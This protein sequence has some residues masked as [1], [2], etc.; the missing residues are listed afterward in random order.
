MK[1]VHAEKKAAEL[2]GLSPRTL[3]RYRLEGRGPSFVR[4]GRRVL[5]REEDLVAWTEK[6]RRPSTWESTDVA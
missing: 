1:P 4:L 2:C 3:E 6:Q 5:Y